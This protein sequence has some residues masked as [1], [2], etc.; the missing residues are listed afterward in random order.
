MLVCRGVGECLCVEVSGSACVW[1][2]RGVL[3]CGGVV[4]REDFNTPLVCWKSPVTYIYV[5]ITCDSLSLSL[6][7]CVCVRVCACVCMCMCVCVCSCC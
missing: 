6:S 4:E 5:I 3:V 1:R 7:L 2:C